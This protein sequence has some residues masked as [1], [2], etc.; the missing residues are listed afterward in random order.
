VNATRMGA[1]AMAAALF[2]AA[3][4][5]DAQR[6]PLPRQQ[7]RINDSALLIGGSNLDIGELNTRLAAFG[8]PA[9]DEQF[10]QVGYVW[11]TGR[12]GVRLGFEL[13]GVTRPGAATA[14]NR[15]RTRLSGGYA[16]FN[17]SQ[18]VFRD[19]GITVRPKV[20]I[21]G[22]ALNL[23]VTDRAAP[24]FD[25]VLAQPGRGVSMATGSLVVDGSLG[26]T[27]RLQP[28]TTQRGARSLM[29]GARAGWTQSLLHGEWMRNGTDAPGGPTAGWGGPHAE[30]MIGRSTRR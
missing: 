13:A 30:F 27:Y 1:A 3:A 25:E 28:R 16:M 20:G 11:S 15:Y 18:D 22:G 17:L 9:F 19:G 10:L 8:Y 23:E 21:G 26:V 2:L 4:P 14:D 12:E 24:P 6:R 29:L 7:V 5:L